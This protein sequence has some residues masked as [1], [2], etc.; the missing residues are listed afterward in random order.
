MSSISPSS[1][2]R[3]LS[4][5]E[6]GEFSWIEKLQSPQFNWTQEKLEE[7]LPA[8]EIWCRGRVGRGILSLAAVLISDSAYE[9]V[10]LASHPSHKGQGQGRELLMALIDAKGQDR[11]WWLEVHESNL[12]AIRLYRNLGFKQVGRRARYYSDGAACLLM[13]REPS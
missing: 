12:G 3:R 2:L 11:P 10:L 9:L 4:L 13:S 1:S 8:H 7:L 5:P 6:L